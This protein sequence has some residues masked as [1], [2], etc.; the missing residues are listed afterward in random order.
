M[1]NDRL[2]THNF[3][4]NWTQ[5]LSEATRA[6]AIVAE[7]DPQSESTPRRLTLKMTD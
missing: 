5:V 2:K 6:V 7:K 1:E 4:L 3:C